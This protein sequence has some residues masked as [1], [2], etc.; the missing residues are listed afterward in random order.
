M[1]GKIPQRLQGFLNLDEFIEAFSSLDED[2]AAGV[3]LAFYA[4]VLVLKVGLCGMFDAPLLSP[5]PPLAPAA[6]AGR[7]TR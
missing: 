7:G 3:G 1:G 6:N 5:P 4:K 2:E